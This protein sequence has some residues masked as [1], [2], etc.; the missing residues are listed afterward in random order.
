MEKN[1]LYLGKQDKE[2]QKERERERIYLMQ[3]ER[4]Y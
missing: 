1:A 4:L 2:D 3:R